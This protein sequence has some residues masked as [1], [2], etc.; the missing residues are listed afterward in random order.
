MKISKKQT[1][2]KEQPI[3][4]TLSKGV[5]LRSM[6]YCSIKVVTK[7]KK[8]YSS[9]QKMCEKFPES[10]FLRSVFSGIWTE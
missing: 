3:L 10:E 2:F 1:F 8:N 4:I 5:V 6:V 9:R 7:L